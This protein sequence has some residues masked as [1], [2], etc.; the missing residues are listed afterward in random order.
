MTAAIIAAALAA[1]QLLGTD[2]ASCAGGQG[3]TIQV[4][5]NGLKDR[6][7][8]LKLEV[9]PATEADWLKDDRDLIAQ[10]KTFRRIRVATPKTGAVQ[11]CIRVPQPG[12]YALLFTHDRDGKN[13]FNIWQDGMGVTG[14][15][16][17]GRSKPTVAQATV[18][19]G[20]GGVTVTMR[21]QY[22]RGLGG[23]GPLSNG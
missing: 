9:Y 8:N 3:P 18:D 2:G 15:A 6:T 16:K 19:V 22:L 23:F 14:A 20:A 7:G 21:A 11:L 4:T 1:G 12:R 17:M 13:K 5:V 10:G